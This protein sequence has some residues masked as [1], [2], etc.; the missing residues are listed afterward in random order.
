MPH[1]HLRFRGRA[2]VRDDAVDAD[3]EWHLRENDGSRRQGRTTAGALA[4]LLADAGWT[5]DP[6][7]VTALVPVAETLAVT[8]EVPGRNAAAQRSAARY[9]VEEFLT[10][11]IDAMHVACGPLARGQPVRCLATPRE[12]M[13]TWLAVLARANVEPGL[14]TADAMMLPSDAAAVSVLFEGDEALVRS[15]DQVASVDADNLIAALAAIRAGFDAEESPGLRQFNGALPAGDVAAAGFSPE[16]AHQAAAE[17]MAAATVPAATVAEEAGVLGFLADQEHAAAAAPVN[18]LQ[19]D[20][21]VKRQRAGAWAHWRPAAALAGV[22]LA[23]AL[24]LWTAE[25]VWAGLRADAQREEARALYREIFDTERA[26]GSPA[27]I[28]RRRL[29]Q[30]VA[31][32]AGFHRLLG[33]LGTALGATG[34]Y[35]MRSVSFAE[36]NGLVAEVLVRDYDAVETLQQSLRERG[37]TVEVGSSEQQQARVRT[38]IRIA[39]GAASGASG[40]SAASG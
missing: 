28:M 14:L 36:R 7:N 26:P 31:N 4:E 39:G 18:L 5:E 13:E 22:G 32:P 1:L 25:G 21:A 38:S 16:A 6:A 27:M 9:A 19:D 17:S 40:A 15:G 35:E 2:Q 37:L 12:R 10:E 30:A 29:G 3:L 24:A 23:I 33:E 8:C 11:D 20:F 34:Q